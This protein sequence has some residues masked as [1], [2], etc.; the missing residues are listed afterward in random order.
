MARM[1]PV[2]GSM[3][4]TDPGPAGQLLAGDL[5]EAGRDGEG[6]VWLLLVLVRRFRSC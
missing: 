4:T 3:A 5:L 1:A 6:D 2:C